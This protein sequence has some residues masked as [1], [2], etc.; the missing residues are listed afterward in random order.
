M[1]N[2]QERTID[3]RPKEEG[4]ACINFVVGKRDSS[5]ERGLKHKDHTNV[6]VRIDYKPFIQF[7]IDEGGK[8]IATRHDTKNNHP[9]CSPSELHLLPSHRE[10]SEDDIL[11]MK[12][13]KE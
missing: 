13:L 12:Q 10:M 4:Y 1:F 8:C 3:I 6:D 2:I 5:K 11:F 9:L 7:Y